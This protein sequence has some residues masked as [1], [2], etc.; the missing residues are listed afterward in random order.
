MHG[1]A[2]RRAP[3][4]LVLLLSAGLVGG[5]KTTVPPAA[6]YPPEPP[7]IAAIPVYGPV[8]ASPVRLREL[9]GVNE[10]AVGSLPP[11]MPSRPTGST[12]GAWTEVQTPEGTGWLPPP[13]P[14]PG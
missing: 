6:Y 10:P 1:F 9:P 3:T 5:C 13:P 2:V 14:P 11:G 4:A 12:R 7:A 8:F